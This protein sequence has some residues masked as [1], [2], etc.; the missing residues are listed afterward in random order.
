MKVL[1]KKEAAARVGYHPV[2]LMRLAAKGEFP[3]AIQLGPNAVGFLEHEVDAWIESK[4]RQ[5]DGEAA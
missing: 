3:K 2:H 4:I 5:R 1:R